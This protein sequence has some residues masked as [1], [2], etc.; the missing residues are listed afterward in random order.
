M[1]TAN[2][3]LEGV[4]AAL[5]ALLCALRSKGL[6]G[7]E[8]IER[9]LEQAEVALA[10]DAKR[11]SELRAANIDAICFP[12]R[13]LRLANQAPLQDRPPAFSELATRLGQTKAGR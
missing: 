12:L 9:A 3:Q 4:Y 11:P 10:A 5:A 8:E 1:N 2:L 13:Y 6:L 7:Q